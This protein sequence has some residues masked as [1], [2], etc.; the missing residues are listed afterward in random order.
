MNKENK[1]VNTN[2]NDE[3]NYGFESEENVIFLENEVIGILSEFGI[4]DTTFKV[5]ADK[6]RFCLIGSFS[7]GKTSL[8]NSLIGNKKFSSNITAETAVPVMTIGSDSKSDKF[9]GY[10][11]EQDSFEIIAED[12]LNNKLDRLLPSGWLE[13]RITNSWLENIKHVEIVDLPGIDSGFASHDAAIE[14]KIK[15]AEIYGLVISADDGNLRSS[16]KTAIERYIPAN[17]PVVIIL[18]KSDKKTAVDIDLISES[19]MDSINY[20]GN[21]NIVGLYPV[22]ARTGQID[23]L[24]SFLCELEGLTNCLLTLYRIEE[25]L[26]YAPELINKLKVL[27]S[28]STPGEISENIR[29]LDLESLNYTKDQKIIAE[30]KTEIFKKSYLRECCHRRTEKAMAV[31]K[32][33][34]KLYE[35][36][37]RADH[38]A[39]NVVENTEN[40]SVTKK[41][42]IKSIAVSKA[43]IIIDTGVDTLVDFYMPNFGKCIAYRTL[44]DAS[45]RVLVF[46]LHGGQRGHDF[47]FNIDHYESKLA[48]N[49]EGN[50]IGAYG[51]PKGFLKSMTHFVEIIDIS[52]GK[53]MA[54]T[55]LDANSENE[56]NSIIIGPE[57]SYCVVQLGRGKKTYLYS[58]NGKSRLSSIR[59]GLDIRQSV[60]IEDEHMK[61]VVIDG[62]D[63]MFLDLVLDQIVGGIT[64]SQSYDYYTSLYPYGI[65]SNKKKDIIIVYNSSST[66]LIDL[67]TNIST[68]LPISGANFM[69][70]SPDG[71]VLAATDGSKIIDLYMIKRGDI[72]HQ[73]KIDV[74]MHISSEREGFMSF[75]HSGSKLIYS[76]WSNVFGIDI[77]Y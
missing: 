31:V 43:K 75:D 38:S 34:L 67:N 65:I 24:K 54:R 11:D 8:V 57:G 4:I 53:R 55:K 26:R 40:N 29:K 42:T 74:D 69:C 49:E 10:R 58:A 27:A 30:D 52:S 70:I 73:A 22:S 23:D 6:I 1:T 64:L 39:I 62:K 63:L 44:D 50:I 21:L 12:V 19:I 20:S 5:Y 56:V 71:S 66:E 36:I 28:E 76:G 47:D 51:W 18:T 13:A 2:I 77:K 33:I 59:R 72:R 45:N 14:A 60:F 41:Q 16:V 3:N 7:S 46:N 25:L 32:A 17:K 35:A 68:S 48:I 37:K 15:K 9:I 61:M